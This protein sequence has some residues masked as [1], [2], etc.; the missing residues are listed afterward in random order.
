MKRPDVAIVGGG[1]I[2]LSIAHALSRDGIAAAVL[3]AGAFGRA[4][5]W[6]GAGIISPGSSRPV[7]LPMARL[8][9]LSSGLFP[10]WSR[11]LRE[12]TGIDNGYRRSGGID[13]ALDAADEESLRAAAGRWRLEGIAAERLE[14]ADL[15][16]IEPSLGDAIRSGYYLADRAQIRNPRHLKALV[17]A[18]RQRGVVLWPG[19]AVLG[20][21]RIGDRVAS[22]STEAGPIACG[23]VVVAAGPWSGLLLPRLETPPIRGQIVLL[24]TEPDALQRIIEHRRNYLVPRDDGR[25]LV[26]ASEEHAGFDAR[27][28]AGA[29]RDL[30]DFALR[31]CPRLRDAEVESTWAGLRPGSRDSRPYLGRMPE[32]DNVLVATGHGRAG[33]QLSTGTAEIMADLARGREPSLPLDDFRP[34]RSGASDEEDKADAFRS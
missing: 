18:C 24:R 3:D 23:T 6:A 30:I 32:W 1:V 14:A 34:E 25:V 9:T 10:E 17:A 2:G 27:P 16:R 8:R 33:L 19:R 26:G 31:I 12:E 20:F 15:R 11:S 13:V 5:S 4:S 29:A 7:A 21:D 22:L 28:T